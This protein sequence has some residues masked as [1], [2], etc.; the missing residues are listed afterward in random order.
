MGATVIGGQLTWKHALGIA[1][2]VFVLS[3]AAL[4]V[5]SS[6]G[7]ALPQNSWI[8]VGVIVV[9]AAFVLFMGNEV[10]VYLR[11]ESV[12]PLPPQRARSTLVASQACVLAGA[13]F[14]GWYAG[15][16]AVNVDRLQSTSGPRAFTVALVLTLACVA[17]I[18]T[19]LVVQWWCKLPEDDE[20][21]RRRRTRNGPRG[22]A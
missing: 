10:R 11:G 21:T 13:A 4:Q 17:L 15:T 3:Y 8:A 14:A 9:M 6:Q 19:G 22:V 12:R 7:N 2:V 16:V 18:A 5:W 20:D 1:A